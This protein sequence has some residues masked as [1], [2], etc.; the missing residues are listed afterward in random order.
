MDN[1][2]FLDLLG[3]TNLIPG[4][5]STEMAIHIGHQRAGWRGLIVAGTL[6]ILPAMLIV[7]CLAWAYVRFGTTP[8][9]TSLM[10]GVKPVIIAV[11][12]QALV[13]LGR[14]A[15]K[16]ILTAVVVLIALGLFFVGVNE[17]GLLLVAGL[18]VMVVENW[19]RLRRPE[20]TSIWLLPGVGAGVSAAVSAAT[21]V[22]LTQLFLVFLKVGSILYGSGY[23]LLA[24]LH[25]DLVE[26]L[27]WLTDRQLIDAIAIGQFTPGPVFTTATF[28]CPIV[29]T[30]WIKL[31]LGAG[32]E[33]GRRHDPLRL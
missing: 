8:A 12:A 19:R 29:V 15:I 4:P 1:Q 28:G 2:R 25:A 16:S 32:N 31:S 33:N 17:L 20:L 21:P 22:S 10:Y 26:R 6:F 14:A 18:V 5:N 11:V 30:A 9:A 27:H 13:A 23:V 7:L 24:F 3:A